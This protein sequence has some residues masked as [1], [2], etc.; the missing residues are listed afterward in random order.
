MGLSHIGMWWL[1]KVVEAIE[2]RF[3][4]HQLLS[5]HLHIWGLDLPTFNLVGLDLTNPLPH[6]NISFLYGRIF[7]GRW[8]LFLQLLQISL[9][10]FD[11]VLLSLYDNLLLVSFEL[12][13]LVLVL[14]KCHLLLNTLKPIGQ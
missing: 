6:I 2:R 5:N 3:G 13:L 10:H 7:I 9:K 8:V 12:I 11:L 4:L 1:G 14:L